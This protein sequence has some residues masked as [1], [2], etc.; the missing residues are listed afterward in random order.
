MFREYP[1]R[2]YL[3]ITTIVLFSLLAVSLSAC[4][5]APVNTAT[6][7]PSPEV[8]ITAYPSFV[9]GE[10]INI[11]GCIRVRDKETDVSYAILWTPDVSATIE[12]DKVKIITGIVRQN[13]SEVTIQFGDTARVS[14][15][16]TAFPDEQLLKKLPSSCQGPYWVIGFEIEPIE[17]TE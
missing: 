12:G 8:V 17:S 6:A 15:G 9:I 3:S 16:E 10:I 11:D 1:L 2:L 13:T 7:V 14:G 5:E 4:T